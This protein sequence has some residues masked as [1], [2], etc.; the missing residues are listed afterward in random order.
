MP[1][2]CASWPTPTPDD[3][4]IVTLYGDALFLLEPRRGSRDVNDPNVQR[5]H[6]V[7]ESV[8]SKDVKHP[9]RVPPVRS[10]NR[11][12]RRAR[13]GRTVRRVSRQLHPWRQPH[14]SHA[15]A[16]LERGRTMGRF[17][18]GEPRGLAFGPE[19]GHRR[20]IRH[21][22]GAQPSHAALR[23]VDGRA[24]RHRHA[25]GTDYA[26]LTNDTSFQVM[27]LDQVRSIRRGARGDQSPEAARSRARCGTSR[28]ATRACA[29]ARPTTPACSCSACSTRRTPRKPWCACT[30]RRTCSGSWRASSKE[31]SRAAAAICQR[32][33]A[34][35]NRP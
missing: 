27:T 31:R 30:P 16:H 2:P 10:R 23:G 33:S 12:D 11:I 34:R 9:G 28:R 29:R 1:R 32:R 18:A 20:R 26:K 24:G 3:L 4:D 21:L 25:C 22:P 35:S 5:L 14:Q 8:L 13:A 6:K 19:G 17:G 7:L 15:L